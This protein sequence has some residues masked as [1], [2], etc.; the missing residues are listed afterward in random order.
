MHRYRRIK[1]VRS[2]ISATHR[3]F[4]ASLRLLSARPSSPVTQ[5]SLILITSKTSGIQ[6]ICIQKRERRSAPAL[7]IKYLSCTENNIYGIPKRM[8][9]PLSTPFISNRLILRRCRFGALDFAL[10]RCL[11]RLCGLR[12][13]YGC[14]RFMKNIIGNQRSGLL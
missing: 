14:R 8:F 12:I 4:N 13:I 11:P 3:Y 6:T 10:G 7:K 1:H 2:Y 9:P 5:P